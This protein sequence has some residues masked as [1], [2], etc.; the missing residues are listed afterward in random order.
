MATRDDVLKL[1]PPEGVDKLGGYVQGRLDCSTGYK[2]ATYMWKPKVEL[3][4]VKAVIFLLHGVLSHSLFEW[5]A[6]DEDNHRV[7]LKDSLIE[8][9]LNAGAVVLAHDHPGHGRSTGL[10]AYVDSHDELRDTAIEVVSHFKESQELAGKKA[11]MVGMSMGATT[12]IRVC[13]KQPGLLDGYALL[14]PAV[15]PPDDMFGW[16]G[17][18]L[19]AISP[20]LGSLV[21]RLPV[22]SLPPSLDDCVRDAVEKDGLIHRG[23]IRVRMCLEFLRVYS[24]IN[25][26]AHLL[27]FKS[28]G[29]FV[30]GI[31]TIVSPVGMKDFV[32]RIRSDD[33]NML[34]FDNLGHD[35]CREKGCEPVIEAIIKWIIDRL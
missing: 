3:S 27:N 21:P 18:F 8:S 13:E 2:I 17:R 35:I 34:V 22:L 9:F 12:A 23:A 25:E 28:V 5:L 7:L 26:N 20:L 11:F 15:R 32:E 16:H 4:E 6:P 1:P 14:S 33:K 10:H 19:K 24:E 30:G 31:D 29:I